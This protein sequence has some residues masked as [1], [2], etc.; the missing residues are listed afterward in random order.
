MFT[1]SLAEGG[2]GV[3]DRVTSTLSSRTYAR[4]RLFRGGPF[5]KDRQ[6]L[7]GFEQELAALKRVSHGH[8][9][10]LGWKLTDPK[11]VGLIMLP[12]ADGDLCS[13]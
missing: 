12:V 6:T 8:I 4:K 1:R 7:R 13:F 9:I 2:F 3:V 11:F 5:Q 10:E